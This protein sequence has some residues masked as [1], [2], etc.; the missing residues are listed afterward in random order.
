V[1]SAPALEA[2][3]IS[4]R[5]GKREVLTDV[6]LAANPGEIV[7]LLGPN[8]AGKS[9]LVRVLAATHRPT[10]GQV[11]LQGREISGF[12]RREIARR[13]A[14]VPQESDVAFGFTVREVVMMGRAPHQSGLLFARDED[15]RAVDAALARSELVEL[16]DRRVVEL[17]GGERRRVTI[18]RALAQRP[19]VLVL[20]EPAA[21]LDVRHA[22]GVYELVRGEVEERHV[23]C[24]AVMHDLAAAARWADRVVLLAEGRVTAVGTAE[25]VLTP[26]RL[27]ETF[28][29]PIRVGR[30]QDGDTY[31]LPARLSK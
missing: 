8:G 5:Y 6:S 30:D 21:H 4:A 17:S 19:D 18:A 12:E 27:A 28:G 24:V 3:G 16:A 2:R 22:V 15:T 11:F 29:L 31:F 7:A 14:V 20:D 9:T 23:A 1:E 25:E 26:D 13:L 10:A